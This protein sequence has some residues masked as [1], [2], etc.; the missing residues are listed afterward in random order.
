MHSVRTLHLPWPTHHLFWVKSLSNIQPLPFC[1]HLKARLQRESEWYESHFCIP[2]NKFLVRALGST[3]EVVSEPDPRK[4][5]KRFWGIG[6]GRSI[7][8]TQNAGTLPIGSRLHAYSRL[9]EATRYSSRRQKIS[10]ICRQEKLLE[11]I[12]ALIRPWTA[13]SSRNK[14]GTN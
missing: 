6:W 2:L 10:G 4:F 9:L 8:C 3:I 11:H 13:R 12:L 5:R 14:V 1:S 7:L